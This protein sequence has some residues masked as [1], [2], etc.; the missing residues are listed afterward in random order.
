[1]ATKRRSFEINQPSAI[2]QRAEEFKQAM[3]DLLA[4]GRRRTFNDVFMGV[5]DTAKR[6][7]PAKG[8]ELMRLHAYELLNT[9]HSRGL[10]RRE[11]REYFREVEGGTK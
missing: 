5:Q 4:D 3:I 9:A 6:L 2:T 8:S 7:Y 1:M 10:V 11:G